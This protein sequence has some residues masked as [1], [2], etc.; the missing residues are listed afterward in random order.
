MTK[1][2][3]SAITMLSHKYKQNIFKFPFDLVADICNVAFQGRLSNS[4]AVEF[5]GR[6]MAGA[7]W[8]KSE[9]QSAA[10]QACVQLPTQV[11]TTG[12]V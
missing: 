10:S 12:L 6:R 2:N 7:V 11:V 5:K 1:H 9:D 8:S 4:T 3:S